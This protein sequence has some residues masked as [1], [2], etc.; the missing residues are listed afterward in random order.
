VSAAEPVVVGR[1]GA[2]YGV[3]GWVHIRSY[4]SPPE[5]LLKYLPWLISDHQ[6]GS[7]QSLEDVQSRAH[8][9]GFVARLGA[10]ADRDEAAALAGKLIAIPASSLPV[11]DENEYYW[12]DL[13]GC[14]VVN[15]AN[16]RLGYVDHRLE[17]GANDVL[18]IAPDREE[19]QNGESS[20]CLIPFVDLYI[21]EVD[22]EARTVTVAWDADWLS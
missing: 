8:K 13:V 17:T 9:K 5:N 22:A 15:E 6:G 20:L 16:E 1:I 10:I 11:S 2:P 21:L 7:W 19:G 14:R 18:V 4:T 12:R 3:Q